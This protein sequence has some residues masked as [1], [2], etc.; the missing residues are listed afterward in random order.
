LTDD[1]LHDAV[2]MTNDDLRSTSLKNNQTTPD[3]EDDVN[4][5]QIVD[6]IVLMLLIVFVLYAVNTLSHGEFGRIML[7]MF[8]VEFESLKLT[9]YMEKYQIIHK[10]S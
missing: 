5:F 4:W 8:P 6:K 10:K 7:G 9:K 2:E 1:Q 3:I